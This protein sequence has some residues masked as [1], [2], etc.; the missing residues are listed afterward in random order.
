MH[1]P[2]SFRLDLLVANMWLTKLIIRLA[3]LTALVLLISMN[4]NDF[5]SSY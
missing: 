4:T 2:N 3:K 5:Q 1:T